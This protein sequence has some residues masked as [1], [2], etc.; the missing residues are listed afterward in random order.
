MWLPISP[1]AP[2]I[3]A[4]GFVLSGVSCIDQSAG[5]ISER[6]DAPILKE[7]PMYANS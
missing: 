4:S 5:E 7:R 6:I 3:Q 1:L 2:V